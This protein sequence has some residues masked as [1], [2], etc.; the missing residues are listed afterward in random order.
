[1]V[2]KM[3]RLY[4][5]AL[6]VISVII[7]SLNVMKEVI[8]HIIHSQMLKLTPE[9]LLDLFLRNQHEC[10]ELCRDSIAVSRMTFNERLTCCLFTFAVVIYITCIKVRI[11]CFQKS[12][13]HIIQLIIVKIS[14]TG[15]N[16][17]SH[18]TE[19]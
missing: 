11:A 9:S 6:S 14:R 15:D 7:D 12:I 8:I 3:R 19:T 1:M 18:H 10:R 5:T 16:R 2:E 13:Y 17:K 4:D